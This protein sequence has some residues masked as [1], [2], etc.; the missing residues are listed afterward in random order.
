MIGKRL[1]DTVKWDGWTRLASLAAVV[2][3][4]FT[5]QTIVTGQQ[6]LQL[7]T[8]GQFKDSYTKAIEE[9]GSQNEV[10]RTA[11][12]YELAD[13]ADGWPPEHSDIE[14]VLREFL[15]S[16]TTRDNC[17]ETQN[18]GGDVKAAF[19]SLYDGL[20]VASV[21]NDQGIYLSAH[22]ACV[23]TISDDLFQTKWTVRSDTIKPNEWD[24]E[25]TVWTGKDLDGATKAQVT[26]NT[27][28]V[29]VS[30]KNRGTV[31]LSFTGTTFDELLL[32]P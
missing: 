31:A 3:L 2:A 10:T 12:I 20:T 25:A 26:S 23:A 8:T 16:R 13:L 18:V 19:D 15:L 22:L 17:D 7:N 6:Q 30:T 32:H 29:N 24:I 11:G 14:N 27:S 1:R 4:W 28:W 21:A 9:I 5:A